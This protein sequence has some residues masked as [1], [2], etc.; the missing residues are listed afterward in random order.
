MGRWLAL[1]L[2]TFALAGCDRNLEPYRPG[3]EP[4]Q[5]D[6]SRIFPEGAEQAARV[7]SSLQMPPAPEPARGAGA[8]PPAGPG[9]AA[10]A[11]GDARPIRGTVRVSDALSDRVAPGAVLF[12]IARRGDAG[13]PLAV[14]RVAGPRFPLDFSIGPEDRM[15]RTMPFEGELRLSARLDGDGNAMSRE[16]GDLQGSADG[17]FEPGASGVE[18]VLDEIL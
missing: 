7:D 12:L 17:G 13:P 10:E 8:A 5:P 1:L 18:I 3:E 14:V 2:A 15:I 4:E 16:P 11:A 9:G 6:L